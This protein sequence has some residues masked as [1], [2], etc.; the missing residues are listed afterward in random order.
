MMPVQK[1][2]QHLKIPLEV[3]LL[4]TNNFGEDH[5]IGEGG[6]GKV[7]K[8]KLLLSNGHTTVALKRLD[9]IRGQGDTEFW[10]EVMT[11]SLYK[12]ENIVSLLGYCDESGE[13]I[14]AYEYASN[15][16]LDSNLN[17]NN[18]TWSQ[19]LKICIGAA[20][21]LTHLHSDVGTQER[22]W[23]RDVKSSNIL[24]DEKWNAKITDFGLS[25]F[26]PANRHY[27]H[28]YSNPVGTLGYCDPLYAETGLLTKESDVY[29]F[30]VVLFEVLCGRVCMPNIHERQSLLTLVRESYKQKKLN[31][32]VYGNI[33]HEINRSSLKAFISIAYPCLS[34]EREERPLMDM[35]VRTLNTALSYQTSFAPEVNIHG[36]ARNPKGKKTEGVTITIHSEPGVVNVVTVPRNVNPE[37]TS[38]KPAKNGKD[39]KF[40]DK[41]EKEQMNNQIKNMQIHGVK[42]NKNQ[43]QKGG[44]TKQ[45]KQPQQSKGS[46]DQTMRYYN[47]YPGYGSGGGGSSSMMNPRK[48]VK[49]KVVESDESDDDVYYD[50]VDV[51]EHVI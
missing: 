21:G 13:K 35:I 4:E 51:N 12:H 7:Y 34:L 49:S 20:R 30:G 33:K 14:L 25:K 2:F 29:S 36:D 46:Q 15:G 42:N 48:S 3:I 19:R 28:L 27:S 32:I 26:G 22:V 23:H 40:W 44:Q 9:R 5:R 11:L 16:S 6:F 47:G 10:K 24:L 50:D 37:K 38:K 17:N 41:I 45:S 8:A 39:D 18:L 43:L 31:E 1:Q